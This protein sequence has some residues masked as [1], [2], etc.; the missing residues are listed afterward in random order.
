MGQ[1]VPEIGPNK[2]FQILWKINGWGLP[3]FSH[4]PA[5]AQTLEI[6][7]KVFFEGDVFQAENDSISYINWLWSKIFGKGFCFGVNFLF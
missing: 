5:A 2:V 4:E 1:K 7:I 6:A 3:D